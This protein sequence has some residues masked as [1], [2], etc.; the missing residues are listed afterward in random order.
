MGEADNGRNWPWAVLTVCSGLLSVIL[1]EIT[2]VPWLTN[3]GFDATG[4]FFWA[5]LL[6]SQLI[7]VG[8]A[9]AVLVSAFR[10]KPH[11]SPPLY[12]GIYISAHAIEL[13]VLGNPPQDI[14]LYVI[15]IAMACGVWFTFLWLLLLKNRR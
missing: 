4:A 7:V 15:A 9:T 12:A 6:P 5:A 3:V 1:S 11:W 14:A 2:M 10:R 13:Q 8:I